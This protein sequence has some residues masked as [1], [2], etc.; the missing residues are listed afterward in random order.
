MFNAEQMLKESVAEV[1]RLVAVIDMAITL[2]GNDMPDIDEA[3]RHVRHI[4]KYLYKNLR[5]PQ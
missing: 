2:L 5:N 3:E 4:Q 1:A